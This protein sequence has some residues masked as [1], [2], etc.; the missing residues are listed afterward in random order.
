MRNFSLVESLYLDL[1]RN[2]LTGLV[3]QQNERSVIPSFGRDL[4]VRSLDIPM[5]TD[6]LD[7]PVVGL[8][9]IG[10]RRLEN[11]QLAL[12]SVDS[13]GVAGDFVECGVWKG[14]ASIF[15]AAVETVLRLRRR[16]RGKRR[17][18]WL[19]DSFQG[20]P[21]IRFRQDYGL[22]GTD[23]WSTMDYVK[24]DQA[25]VQRNIA[26][27]NFHK[28]GTVFL[29]PGFLSYHLKIQPFPSKNTVNTL[30]TMLCKGSK[31]N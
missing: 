28:L 30:F 3:Y 8:T 7:W 17:I 18:I 6:G 19:L 16:R 14:G 26:N 24:V 10:L 20:F 2:L 27:L 25:S 12:E 11:I 9:M 21:D 15:A 1:L 4:R 13:A 29:L 5:R 31:F 23:D 22:L